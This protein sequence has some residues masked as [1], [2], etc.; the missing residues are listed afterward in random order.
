MNNRPSVFLSHETG[1]N[2]LSFLKSRYTI[3]LEPLKEWNITNL[4]KGGHKKSQFYH[5]RHDIT[6]NGNW[7]LAMPSLSSLPSKSRAGTHQLG[8]GGKDLCDPNTWLCPLSGWSPQS[9]NRNV[10]HEPHIDMWAINTHQ[11]AGWEAQVLNALVKLSTQMVINT[12][13]CPHHA[14]QNCYGGS[15]SDFL[16]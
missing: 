1:F 8:H 6:A 15:N 13:S 16:F 14:K 11:G 12:L 2:I 3:P 4:M 7:Q 9:I 10:D 5:N